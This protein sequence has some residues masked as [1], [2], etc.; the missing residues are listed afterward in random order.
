MQI[1]PPFRTQFQLLEQMQAVQK[2]EKEEEEQR[3]RDM[4][5]GVPGGTRLKRGG[6]SRE[7]DEEVEPVSVIDWRLSAATQLNIRLTTN[8]NLA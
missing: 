8:V 3:E 4:A 5:N 6:K 7:K 2:R 1:L